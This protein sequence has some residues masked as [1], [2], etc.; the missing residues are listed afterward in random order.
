MCERFFNAA[1]HCLVWEPIT[2]RE[3]PDSQIEKGSHDWKKLFIFKAT[4][5]KEKLTLEFD[6][7]KNGDS[8]APQTQDIDSE[9][10]EKLPDILESRRQFFKPLW[11]N[12]LHL[13]SI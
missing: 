8:N 3:F 13:R 11:I 4:S 1:N 10:F 5:K 9:W 2:Q 12:R 7:P 6:K